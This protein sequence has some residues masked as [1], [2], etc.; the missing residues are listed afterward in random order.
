MN[1]VSVEVDEDAESLRYWNCRG[2][3]EMNVAWVIIYIETSVN[4]P[5]Y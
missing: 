2:T 3:T 4:K 5:F 1:G